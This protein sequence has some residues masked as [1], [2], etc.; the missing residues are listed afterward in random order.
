VVVCRTVVAEAADRTSEFGGMLIEV[1][2]QA[3]ERTGFSL[4]P[5][6]FSEIVPCRV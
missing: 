1:F 4:R 6:R 5:F 2:K 3:A